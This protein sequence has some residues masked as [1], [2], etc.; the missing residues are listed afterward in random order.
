MRAT[1]DITNDVPSRVN[2]VYKSFLV[3]YFLLKRVR[4]LPLRMR[5]NQVKAKIMNT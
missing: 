2:A 5:K 3:V 4:R 1:S